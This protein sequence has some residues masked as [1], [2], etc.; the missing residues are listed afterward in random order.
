M[1]E[2]S[3]KGHYRISRRQWLGGVAAAGVVSAIPGGLM[4]KAGMNTR[5]IPNSKEAV[6]VIGMGS[7]RTFDAGDDPELLAR[8]QQVLQVLHDTGG[9][10]VDTSP[11]YGRAE[12]VLGKLAKRANLTD[13]FYWATKV[14]TEG[15]GAGIEQMEQSMELL[16]TDVIDLMQ[17]HNLVDTDTHIDTLRGWRD[18]GRV[19]HLGITHYNQRAYEGLEAAMKKHH[20]DWVQLNYS[21][22]EREAEQRLLPL[23]SDL[24]IAVM[25]NRPFARAAVF[26]KTRGLDVPEW[27]SEFGATSWGK[28]FLKF[29]LAHPAV[30]CLIPATS[31]PHHMEDNAGAGYG[32]DPSAAEQKRMAEFYQGL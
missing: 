31:K 28:F 5:A 15:R 26:S 10:I 21:I 9:T 16:G 24:G 14:W 18:E 29:C 17:V 22:V 6:P 7:S 2:K 1:A 13:D 8:L 30:T 27:A 20:P 25:V 19:R 4:A 32:R 12:T 11:M 3:T 23:A